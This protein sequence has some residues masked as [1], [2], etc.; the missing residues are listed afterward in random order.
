MHSIHC[1]V[2]L[3]RTPTSFNLQ[4]TQIVL[5]QDPIL[6][7]RLADQAMLG[8]GNQFRTRQCSALAVFL[9]DLQASQRIQRIYE[10]EQAAGVRHPNF[11]ALFPISTA[12][13]LGEGHAATFLKQATTDFVSRRTPMPEIEPIQAWSYKNTALAVQ[14]FVLAATS[15]NLQTS[16]MEGMDPR[17]VKEIL[18]IPDR[19]G[20][21]MV[22][23]T[24]Y[25]YEE[26]ATSRPTAVT[27]RL[28]VSEVVFGNTFGAPL[29]WDKRDDHENDPAAASA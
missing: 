19:Y 12:F 22:V 25:E 1:R 9:S 17:R 8:L 24:G 3:K 27:P 15:H 20:I 5:V 23:A 28:D 29:D 11:L 7:N 21:P 6:K 16:I 18:R 14:T 2:N 10:L 4:P 26:E 13:F